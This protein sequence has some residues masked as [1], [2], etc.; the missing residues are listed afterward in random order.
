MDPDPTVLEL[1]DLIYATATDPENWE[2][3]LKRLAFALK[4]NIATLHHQHPTALE[5]TIAVNWNLDPACLTSYTAHYAPLNLWF[6]RWRQMRRRP[7]VYTT[8]TLCPDETMVRSEFYNDWARPYGMQRGA[9]AAIFQ[10]DAVSTILSV[11]RLKDDEAFG[12]SEL[13]LLRALLPH[14]RRALQL[15]NRIQALDQKGSAGGGRARPGD[16][17]SCFAGFQRSYPNG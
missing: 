10:S 4:G 16:A 8:Q 14:L 12:E 13:A 6:A 7:N 11:F 9:G 2:E 5:G 1:I 15:H 3:L 17:G